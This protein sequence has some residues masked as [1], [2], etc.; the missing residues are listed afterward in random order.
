MAND[1][2][3]LK[4]I[5]HYRDELHKKIKEREKEMQKDNNEH[6]LIYNALGLQAKKDIKLTINKM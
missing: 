6:Y 4:I 1:E 2:K 3:L 5:S